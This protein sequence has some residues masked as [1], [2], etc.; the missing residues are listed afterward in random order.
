[1]SKNNHFSTHNCYLG[2]IKK[3]YVKMLNNVLE[4]IKFDIYSSLFF[5]YLEKDHRTQHFYKSTYDTAMNLPTFKTG[6]SYSVI[7]CSV[8]SKRCWKEFIVFA[9]ASPATCFL[10]SSIHQLLGCSS[11]FC[12]D[13]LLSTDTYM[14]QLN[15]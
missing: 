11:A 8:N 10:Q 7:S 4:N 2:N 13:A 15:L 9:S 14:I 1:M 6:Q 12:C 3:K 5:S